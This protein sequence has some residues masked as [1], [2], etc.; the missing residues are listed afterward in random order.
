LRFSPT[1]TNVPAIASTTTV[2]GVPYTFADIPS[3][4]QAPSIAGVLLCCV[5]AVADIPA[6]SGFPFCY[7]ILTVAACIDGFAVV[8]CVH[9][10]AGVHGVSGVPAI[11]GNPAV[12]K[13]PAVAFVPVEPSISALADFLTYYK[14]K[15]SC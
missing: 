5:P 8:T 3:L 7:D 10:V 4:P 9:A 1:L 15:P 6:V 11:A 13:G 12:A 14:M 2:A